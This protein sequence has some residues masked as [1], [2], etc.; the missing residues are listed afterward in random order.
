MYEG[1]KCFVG[2][3]SKMSEKVQRYF[4]HFIDFKKNEWKNSFKQK[5]K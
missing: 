5:K 3:F 1:K 2:F 4:F